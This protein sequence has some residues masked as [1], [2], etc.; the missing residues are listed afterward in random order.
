MKILTSIE[1]FDNRYLYTVFHLKSFPVISTLLPLISKSAN[2]HLYPLISIILFLIDPDKAIFFLV[3]C[4]ISFSLER[5]CYKLIK[6]SF[7]RYRPYEKDKRID[8]RADPGDRFSLPSGHTSCSVIISIILSYCCPILT[9]FLSVWSLGVGASRI[10]LGVH[11]PTD[12]LAGGM[13][14]ALSAFA[15]IHLAGNFIL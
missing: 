12:I 2:G 10:Y 8:K 3:S 4:I 13:L 11:Y 6:N 1:N 9:P 7:K 5:P 15:G 14:G